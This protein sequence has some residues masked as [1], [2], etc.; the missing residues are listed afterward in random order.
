[1]YKIVVWPGRVPERKVFRVVLGMKLDEKSR[2]IFA[3]YTFTGL[4]R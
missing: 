1:M 4:G 3:E 2:R